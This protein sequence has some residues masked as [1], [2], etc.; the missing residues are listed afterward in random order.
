MVYKSLHRVLAQLRLDLI[1]SRTAHHHPDRTASPRA[2]NS[3]WYLM[4]PN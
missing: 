3:T 4:S 2:Q 1:A